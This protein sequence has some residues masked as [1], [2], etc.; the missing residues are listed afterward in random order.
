[1]GGIK[2]EASGNAFKK[3]DAKKMFLS[4]AALPDII[5]SK[6]FLK[7]DISYDYAHNPLPNLY[8][9]NPSFSIALLERFIKEQNQE[10]IILALSWRAHQVADVFAHLAPLNGWWGYVNSENFFGPFWKDALKHLQGADSTE[11]AGSFYR[12]DHWMSELV[13]DLFC[14]LKNGAVR[15]KKNT[16]EFPVEYLKVISEI[17]REY[18]D[19]HKTSLLDEYVEIEPIEI[20]EI[21][22]GMEF[23][24]TLNIASCMY[25]DSLIKK[26]SIKTVEKMINEH[27]KFGTLEGMLNLVAYQTARALINPLD[28]WN[29]P[30][31]NPHLFMQG[32]SFIDEVFPGPLTDDDKDSYYSQEL[33]NEW[34]NY[35]PKREGIVKFVLEKTPV[36]PVKWIVMNTPLMTSGFFLNRTLLPRGKTSYALSLRFTFNI[37][38]INRTNLMEILRH[39]LEETD[40]ID[41]SGNP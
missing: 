36:C 14:Y 8:Y 32:N 29:A 39:T 30:K 35:T 4:M 13:I 41:V 2:E 25:F 16:D 27:G 11:L 9:G 19:R 37:R 20:H 15:D 23:S 5:K 31:I 17:S 28:D 12:A 33:E 6:G 24:D 40:V 21:K 1:M 7:G 22:R 3:P 34:K 26:R 18:L 38:E 10:G